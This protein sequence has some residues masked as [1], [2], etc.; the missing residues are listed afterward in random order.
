MTL[1]HVL[2]GLSLLILV[3]VSTMVRA[4]IGF[5]HGDGPAGPEEGAAA[6]AVDVAEPVA[7]LGPLHFGP[8]LDR[9]RP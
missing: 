4:G 2:G 7:T 3:A 1:M 5:E 9:M 8:L 6:D